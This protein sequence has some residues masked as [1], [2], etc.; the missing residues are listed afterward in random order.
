[1]KFFSKIA[2]LWCVSL[3]VVLPLRAQV[4]GAPPPANYQALADEQ[5]DQL[6]G[7]IALYPD[8]L[9]AQVLAGATLPEQIVMAAQYVSSGGDPNQIDQQP[10]DPSVQALARYPDVLK[11]LN[12]NLNWTTA[13]GQAFLYQQQA[14][15]ESVQRL[16]ASAYKLGNLQSTPQQQ[17]IYDPGEIDIVPV[18]PQVIYVPY[19]QPDLVYYRSA[20]GSPYISFGIGFP[21]GAWLSYDFDWGHHHLIYWGRDHPRPANWWHEPP[22]QRTFDRATV[23]RPDHHPGAGIGN[24]GGHDRGWS[25]NPTLHPTSPGFSR[26]VPSRPEPARSEPVRRE[27]VRPEPTRPVEPARPIEPARPAPSR[28]E[29]VRPA[30]SPAPVERHEPVTRP[31][32][33]VSRPSSGGAFNGIQSSHDTRSFSTRGQQSIQSTPHVAPA[34]SAPASRPAAPAGGRGNSDPRKH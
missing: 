1:M 17:I 22:R 13:V 33:P 4:D 15:M 5:L 34:P 26:P 32:A 16:R 7:P 14:V 29:P 24:R 12:D 8:P 31:S 23:W 10:W 30:P 2:V 9:I 6:L 21:I 25:R 19:Y 11:W 18:D 28:P 20:Y 27:P 3:S